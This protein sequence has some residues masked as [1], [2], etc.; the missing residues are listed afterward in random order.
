MEIVTISSKNF[1]IYVNDMFYIPMVL[2]L[3]S[4]SS[5]EIYVYVFS[6]FSIY[7]RSVKKSSVC[8]IDELKQ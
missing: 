7:W 1:E 3:L 5:V 4:M 6:A 8:F 2:C